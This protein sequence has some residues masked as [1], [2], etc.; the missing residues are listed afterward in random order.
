MKQSPIHASE[1]TGTDM[2]R[3][4][5]ALAIMASGELPRS[6][7]GNG[8][9]RAAAAVAVD[10]TRYVGKRFRNPRNPRRSRG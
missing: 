9:P 2:M 4:E 1:L 10:D 7:P 5:R 8:D 3:A 6:A